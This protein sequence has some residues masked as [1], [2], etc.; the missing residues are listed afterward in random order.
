MTQE[1]E[2]RAGAGGRAIL[3]SPIPH[4]ADRRK[5]APSLPSVSVLA[6]DACREAP[7]EVAGCGHF[8]CR[9]CAKYRVPCRECGR[10]GV[11]E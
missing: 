2:D 9:R 11:D 6:C 4:K 8:Y 7:A 1:R 5:S 3:Q 10:P